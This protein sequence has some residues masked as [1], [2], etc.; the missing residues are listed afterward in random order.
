MYGVPG[1]VLGADPQKSTGLL[2]HWGRRRVRKR[3][4]EIQLEEEERGRK[5][6]RREK[7]AVGGKKRGME[8]EGE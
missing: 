2:T 5:R 8:V 1:L 3:Q 6:I 4:T 7:A